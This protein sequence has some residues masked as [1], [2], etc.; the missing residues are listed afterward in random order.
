MR[1]DWRGHADLHR[2]D[3]LV[4][5]PQRIGDLELVGEEVALG[6]AQVVGVEPHVAEVEDAVEDDEARAGRVEQRA[7]EPVA[8]EHRSVG[9]REAGGERQ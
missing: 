8:V 7:V 3:V 1:S 6:R 2:E 4:V 9:V 5:P